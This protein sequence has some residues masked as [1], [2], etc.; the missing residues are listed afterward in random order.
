MRKLKIVVIGAGSASFGQS[1]VTDIVSA[2]EFKE[3]NLELVLV[4]TDE[5]SLKRMEKL[6]NLLKEYFKSNAKISSQIDRKIALIDANYVIV[7]VANRRWDLWQKDFYIPAAYGFKH[8]FGENGGP[9]AAFHT[10]RSLHLMIPIAKDME[11]ICPNAL[12]INFTNPESRMCLGISKLTKIKTIGL[13]HGPFRTLGR[14]S[15]IL[16]KPEDEIDLTVGGINHFHWALDIKDRITGEDLYP[17]IKKKINEFNWQGDTLTPLL[18]KVF[19]LIPYPAPSH[20]GEYFNFTYS[21]AGPKFIDWGIGSISHSLSAKS[22]DLD[23]FVEGKSARPSYELW[24]YNQGERV[25]RVLSG[26]LSLLTEKDLLHNLSFIDKS[27]ELAIPIITDIECEKNKKEM[28][29]NLLN[30]GNAVSNLPEDAI[31]EVP[32]QVN[33][34]G[35]QPVK[36]GA[37]PEAIAG[38]C[39]LQISIQNL[40]VKAYQENSKELLLQA[41]L[42][43]PIVDDFERCKK[44]MET[45]LKVQVEF[46][47]ILE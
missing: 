11:R 5:E 32:I 46:L 41:L 6:A 7:S 9:G 28:A 37:L 21:I 33:S 12:L 20:P 40:L 16:K 45:M 35:I 36:V 19:G 26:E 27:G 10:L 47:P 3:F 30:K 15:E 17:I 38:I 13:C 14:I 23:Y 31:V 34:N 25:R 24:S 43:D 42:I 44:M 39:N 2:Q 18:Y 4:D 1:S 29:A 8:V 22:S